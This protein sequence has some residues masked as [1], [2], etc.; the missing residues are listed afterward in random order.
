MACFD[1]AGVKLRLF[2]GRGGSVGRGGGPSFEAIMA[3]PAG[4]VAGRI[5][6]TEQ[7]EVIASKYSDPDIGTRNLEALVAATLES[8]LT[9]HPSNS[10]DDDVVTELSDHAYTAYRTLVETPGFMQYFLEGTPINAIA[11]LNIGSR[12]AS[13]KTLASIKD[14]RAIPWVFSWSQS[15]VMLPGWFGFGSAVSAYVGRHGDEGLARLRSLYQTSP[16]FQVVL[17]NMEQVLAKAD[18][19]MGRR[20]AELVSDSALADNIFG[21]I[22]AEWQKTHDAFF[23]ITGQ[24]RL[25]ETNPTLHRSLA[26]RFPYLDALNLLQIELLGKLRDNPDDEDILYTIHLTINGMSAVLRNSG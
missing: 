2:H 7:G 15:R 17:S 22:E 4:S 12:P 11:K 18:L 26:N 1:Q 9:A 10:Q 20:Y 16:F 24:G 14:L 13:R 21:R 23:A 25:L 5:R 3:Q 19:G 6:I 8:S